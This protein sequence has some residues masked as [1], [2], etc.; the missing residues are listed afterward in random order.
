MK[1]C[2]LALVTL[3]GC[4]ATKSTP[5]VRLA[6]VR[7]SLAHMLPA[8]SHE[9]GMLK[10]EAVDVTIESVPSTAKATEALLSGGAD[11]ITTTT[12]QLLQ[13]VAEGRDLR[14]FVLTTARPFS[15]VAVAPGRT[16]IHSIRDLKGRTVGVTGLGSANHQFLNHVLALNGLKPADVSTAGIG[17]G[18]TAMAAVERGVVDAAVVSTGEYF[19][20]KARLPGLVFLADVTTPEG[21][22]NIYG[23]EL[24]PMA[25]LA[26]RSEWLDRNPDAARRVA[27]AVQRLLDWLQ[28][29]STEEIHNRLPASYRTDDRNGDIA[30]LEAMKSIWSKN[31]VMPADGLENVRKVSSLTQE[32]I[33]NAQID[34]SKTYTNDFVSETH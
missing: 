11:I 21:A 25:I 19:R 26:A 12:E 30:S 28:S 14:S 3:A 15:A 22:K 6:M 8:L 5:V 10:E 7:G 23:S 20:L 18:L 29:H 17:T 2:L 32:K 4:T 13:V 33:R 34:L 27:R 1:W 16:G 31:G 9:L 24:Y